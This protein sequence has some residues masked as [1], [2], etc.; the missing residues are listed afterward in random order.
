MVSVYIVT[1]KNAHDLNQNIA[2]LLATSGGMDL[3]INI[4][5]NHSDFSL[6][7]KYE[8]SVTV[9]HN[10]L[11]PDFS[12]GHLARS[13]NQA[14]IHGFRDLKNPA[15]EIVITFKTMSFSNQDGYPN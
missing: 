13:W 8:K 9:L 10:S 11:R 3:R 2:S 7:P 5:N 15:S 12:T 14:L 1:Y 4:I 6:N